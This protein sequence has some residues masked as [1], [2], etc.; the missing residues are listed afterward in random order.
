MKT[1]GRYNSVEKFDL[2][3]YI[4]KDGKELKN[5]LEEARDDMDKGEFIKYATAMIE[6]ITEQLRNE[7]NF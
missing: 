7:T 1:E 6:T 5:K 4:E 2:D 3:A